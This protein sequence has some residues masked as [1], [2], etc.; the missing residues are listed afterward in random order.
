MKL[1]AQI[2]HTCAKKN[3]YD[4]AIFLIEY[5]NLKAKTGH[6]Y[7]FLNNYHLKNFIRC[8]VRDDYSF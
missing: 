4:F 8:N 7:I 2:S 6:N 3:F 1:R 5:A